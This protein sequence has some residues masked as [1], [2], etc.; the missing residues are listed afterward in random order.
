MYVCIPWYG[1]QPPYVQY[2]NENL[3]SFNRFE[4]STFSI[5][6]LVWDTY[7]ICIPWYGSQPPY[8]QYQNEN[9]HSF[10]RFEESTFSIST[11]VWDTYHICIPWYGS[12]PPYLPNRKHQLSPTANAPPKI[13]T[14]WDLNPR[15]RRDHGLNVTP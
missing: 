14:L 9:L 1:S 4:E 5:S 12:Q 6:T 7:H 10:N 13:C 2:Q 3:H 11:L 8:V 15:L